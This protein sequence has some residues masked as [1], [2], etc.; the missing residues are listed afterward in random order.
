M[1]SNPK[2]EYRF[3]NRNT[4][5]PSHNKIGISINRIKNPNIQKPRIENPRKRGE[6]SPVPLVPAGSVPAGLQ[7]AAPKYKN[8]Q[9]EKRIPLLKTATNA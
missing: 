7:P 5:T 9:S 2:K 3:M 8:F 4:A 1:I 6:P